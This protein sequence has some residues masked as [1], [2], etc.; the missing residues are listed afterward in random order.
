MKIKKVKTQKNEIGFSISLNSIK[1]QG[2]GIINFTNPLT[3]TDDSEQRNGTRYD[4]KSMDL[5]EYHNELT[6]NHS[7][8]IEDIIGSTFGIKKVANHRVTIDGIKFAIN[9]NALAIYTYNMMLAGFIK[10]FS[11]ETIGP[12]PDNDGVYHDSK[13]VGLSVVVKGNNKSATLNQIVKNSIE[14][15]EGL[16]L[17]TKEIKENYLILDKDKKIC[18]KQSM[19][20]EK[21]VNTK[22]FAVTVNYVKSNGEKIEKVLEPNG[23][24]AVAKNY[25]EIIQKQINEAVEVKSNDVIADAINKAVAPLMSK[26][27]TLE[28]NAIDKDVEEPMYVVPSKNS[29]ESFNGMGWKQVHGKQIEYAW[30]MLKGNNVLAGKKLNEINQ[31]NLER[32]KE[33]GI[34]ENTMTI[35]DFGNF[36]ISP[37][38]LKEIEGVRSNFAPLLSKLDWKETLS[39]QMAWL[40]RS[41]DISMSE[42][43]TCADGSDGEL[44]PISDYSAGINLSNLHELAAVTPVCNAATR[45]LAVDLLSDVAAGYKNDY[46]RKRAQLFIARCQ[47]AVDATGNVAVYN[48]TTDLTSLKSWVDM[49]AAVSENIDNGTYILSNKSRWELI[50]AALGS[51]ISGDV[52]GILQS[53]DLTPILGSSAIIVPNELLPTLNTAETKTF[54]VGGVA[55]SITHAIFYLDLSTFV[56]RTSGGL[57]YDL[58]TEAAYEESGTVKSAFQRN[59]LVLRGSM[60]RNGAIKDT[61]KVAAL[62]APGVS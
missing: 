51:G 9:D 29:I 49:V 19:K 10:D 20:K 43:E 16:G 60:F 32:L 48:T 50:K 8:K 40:S 28:K 27:E 52:V 1:D 53:G 35:A 36:V 24:I 15:A 25:V 47:Q 45:F 38:L 59:E 7:Y 58:S 54:T 33:S 41:G 30:E 22:N 62:G 37:E 12:W 23:F 42:V 17:D 55:V 3:I 46:D 39:L 21:V 11:I 18:H 26:I 31:F 34:V 57:M 61:S 5:S 44:K 13:L 14:Q 6:A 4:I 56:G 2:K